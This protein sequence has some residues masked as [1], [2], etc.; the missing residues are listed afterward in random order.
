MYKLKEMMLMLCFILSGAL[1]YAHSKTIT[2]NEKDW[3]LIYIEA[4]ETTGAS[5]SDKSSSILPTLD[6]HV[7]TVVFNE[8]MG[9]VSVEVATL[10]GASVECLSVPTPNCVQ[11]YIPNTG[12]YTI[13]F[14]LSNGDVH[15]GEFTVTN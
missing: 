9:Q 3:V 4:T 2:S 1:C 8:N 15:A 13:T 11:V 5:G 10:A 7:L 6:G 14:T 12:N